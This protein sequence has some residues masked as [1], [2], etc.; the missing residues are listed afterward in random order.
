M[1]SCFPF[2]DIFVKSAEMPTYPI[3]TYIVNNWTCVP[4]VLSPKWIIVM[5]PQRPG[6]METFL[7]GS[8]SWILHLLL[9]WHQLH[10]L[11][12]SQ[13]RKTSSRK[14]FSFEFCSLPGKTWE[15]VKHSSESSRLLNS[16]DNKNKQKIFHQSFLKNRIKM[17]E[18]N[19]C[20]QT[21]KLHKSEE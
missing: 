15:Q 20:T 18:K 17:P 1:L 3:L 9:S 12:L 13:K 21:H 19:V 6:K 2:P 16:R 7:L 11:C 10:T 14:R 5:S 8:V 4:A